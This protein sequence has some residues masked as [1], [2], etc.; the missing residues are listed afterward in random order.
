MINLNRSIAVITFVLSTYIAHS[1]VITEFGHVHVGIYSEYDSTGVRGANIEIQKVGTSNSL[2]K[3]FADRNGEFEIMLPPG[4][5]R[6]FLR[7]HDFVGRVVV[8]N[9]QNLSQSKKID[10]YLLERNFM[11]SSRLR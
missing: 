9:V 2:C 4:G 10:Y 6:F 7:H 1:Q 3:V 8:I 5:Y 11:P